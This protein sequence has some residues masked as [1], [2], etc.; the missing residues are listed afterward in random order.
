VATHE[1][2]PLFLV[3]DAGAAEAHDTVCELLPEGAL[4]SH[5]AKATPD[6][7]SVSV[8]VHVTVCGPAET[9]TAPGGTVNVGS[10]GA[11]MSGSEVTV[12]AVE[13]PWSDGLTLALFPTASRAETPGNVAPPA[14]S[15]FQTPDGE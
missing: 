14:S 9:L 5:D 6:L 10:A 7:A 1:N 4:S 8:I 2:T 15:A 11:T 12:R 13:N 3:P